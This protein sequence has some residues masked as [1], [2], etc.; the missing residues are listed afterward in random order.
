MA[1]P[2]VAGLAALLWS[3]RPEATVE[4]VRAAIL[5]SGTRLEGAEHGL[6][7]ALEAL[8]RLDETPPAGSELHLSHAHLSLAAGKNR[9]SRTHSIQVRARDGGSSTWTASADAPWIALPRHSGRTPS[10]LPVRIDPRRLAAGIHQAKV[11]LTPTSQNGG[12]ARAAIL[13]IVLRIEDT[14]SA[15]VASGPSCHVRNGVL[16][17]RA[18]SVCSL[19]APG[20]DSRA[21]AQ[22][23]GW[24]LPGGKEVA[25]GTMVGRF[26]RAG[27][28]RVR[29]ASRDGD[30]DELPV[31]VE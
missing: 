25:G 15:I 11:V 3:H 5:A 21:P 17:V 9:A 22:G 27:S 1:A 30:A 7:N 8:R 26:V 14:E 6:V 29:F 13:E 31:V 20:V 2:H 24:Q 19:T 18:G 4:Q 12:P 16:H 28:Y 10:R 23:I